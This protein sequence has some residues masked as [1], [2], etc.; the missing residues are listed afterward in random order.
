LPEK[1]KFPP[2]KEILTNSLRILLSAT[3]LSIILVIIIGGTIGS[4]LL[5]EV[6]FFPSEISSVYPINLLGLLIISLGFGF[7][8][9]ANYYLLVK[10]R[11]GLEA[12]EPFHVPSTLVTAGPYR[13]SRNPIYLGVVLLLLGFAIMFMSL[14]VFFSTVIVFLV[15]W[16]FFVRWEEKKLEE[17]FGE[18]YLTYKNQVR[19][20]L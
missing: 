11:I 6:L 1:E 19:R 2:V 14:T 17:A 13:Y 12:R 4:E 3:I 10:G 8:I 18:Q 5:A 16:R 20:W 15:F 9:T 7:I